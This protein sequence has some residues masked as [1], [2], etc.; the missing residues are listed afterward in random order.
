M[1]ETKEQ[2]RKRADLAQQAKI[3]VVKGILSGTY[4]LPS[5]IVELFSG[6]FVPGKAE[7]ALRTR[8]PGVPPD[9]PVEVPEGVAPRPELRPEQIGVPKVKYTSAD[10]ARRM[11]LDPDAPETLIAQLLAPDPFV[12]L[13]A[14][15]LAALAEGFGFL[16]ALGS[17]AQLGKRADK[18]KSA[19][20]S[21]EEIAAALNVTEAPTKSGWKK[22]PEKLPVQA[23][24]GERVMLKRTL[25][26]QIMA[27]DAMKDLRNYM[28]EEELLM[29]TPDTIEAIETIARTGKT[30]TGK[31]I[32]I[33]GGQQIPRL[34]KEDLSALAFAGR[35]KQG[36][37]RHG[38]EQLQNVF[39]EDT[40]RFIALLA[41]T[42]PRTS[43]EMNLENAL[44]VWRTWTDAGRPTDS[45]EIRR[46]MG[47]SVV[48]T[49]TE[50]SVMNVWVNNSVTAL[51]AKDPTVIELSGPK[52]DSFMRNLLSNLDE[53]TLDTWQGRAYNLLQEVF[54]GKIFKSTEGRGVKSPGYILSAA[55]T[56]RA[57][58]YLSKRT[59][60]TWK[61][62]EVQE[63]VWSFVKALY[64]KRRSP[65]GRAK[66]MDELYLE[67]S[68]NEIA[69]VPDF[70]SL[71]RTDKYGSILEGTEYGRRISS[72]EQ[73]Q[74]S[75]E[76]Y[77]A[78]PYRG[79]RTD[80]ERAVG[81]LEQQYRATDTTRIAKAIRDKI[82][83]GIVADRTGTGAV[84]RAFTSESARNPGLELRGLGKV[85]RHNLSK[86]D[87]GRL[88]SLGVSTPDYYELPQTI[89]AANVFEQSIKRSKEQNPF[90]ASVYVYTPAEYQHKRL[91]LTKDGKTGFAVAD[92]GDIVSVFNTKGSG[93]RASTVSM[94]LLA[95][96]N[97]GTKLDAF[98]TIL[99]QLYSSVGFR[100][101]SR[102]AWNDDFA[103]PGW[104]KELFSDYNQGEP[105][106]VFMHYDPESTEVF[107][108]LSGPYNPEDQVRT[109][110]L[111]DEYDDAVA[112]QAQNVVESQ[113]RFQKLKR[114][115]GEQAERLGFEIPKAPWKVEERSLVPAAAT[116]VAA[117]QIIEGLPL[118]RIQELT[119][120]QSLI[121][122]GS[123]L[124]PG[125]TFTSPALNA[126]REVSK[127]AL[128]AKQWLRQLQGRGV[129]EDEIEWTGVGDWLK[130]RKGNVSKADLEEYLDANQIQIQEVVYGN[131]YDIRADLFAA[132]PEPTKF[133]DPAYQLPGG[134][135]YR[136]LVL[137][138]PTPEKATFDPNKVTF[139]RDR[140]SVTQGTV[141]I[142]Y[143]GKELGNFGDR[144][145][146]MPDGSYQGYND[147]E[148]IELAERRLK[149]Y[150][151]DIHGENVISGAFR[152]G[153]YDEPNVVAHI[154][155]NERVDAD[156]NKVLFIEEIQSDWAQK[157]RD[158]GFKSPEQTK[159]MEEARRRREAIMESLHPLE[160]VRRWSDPKDLS[161]ELLAEYDQLTDEIHELKGGVPEAPFIMDTN[162]WVALSLKRMVRWAADNKFDKIGWTTGAQQAARY[163]LSKH[164]SALHY[165]PESG[166]LVAYGLDER[167]YRPELHG[168]RVPL[169][170]KMVPKSELSQHIGKEAARKLLETESVPLKYAKGTTRGEQGEKILGRYHM[171]EDQ[172]LEI[173]GEGMKGFY[174]QIVNDQAKALGK[175]YGAKVETSDI[176]SAHSLRPVTDGRQWRIYDPIFEDYWTN[177]ETRQI[178][179]FKSIEDAAA[180]IKEKAKGIPVS[181]LN[182]TPKLRDAARKGLPYMVVLPPVV[183]GS[184]MMQEESPSGNIEMLAG[185]EWIQSDPVPVPAAQ[186]RASRILE[187]AVP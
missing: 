70:A 108:Q 33:L 77:A 94:L 48:G 71:I 106:V 172:E 38:A 101:S 18:M 97:G 129:K 115:P 78:T 39:G 30:R 137:T 24:G 112:L 99:P 25:Q 104:N 43:V 153:H 128:P 113:Q 182:L 32:T 12:G 28:T 58:D 135:N 143:D 87:Q 144:I 157:G 61:P 187:E 45:K 20:K 79:F 86:Q 96:E 156:G 185:G 149:N 161:P 80:I 178:P 64:E 158:Q 68:P 180:T 1:A 141:K 107:E 14:K 66:S 76:A 146:L 118:S 121:G 60:T 91:F 8:P 73:F 114:F 126:V 53:V 4:G 165:D 90:G 151:E 117:D 37:Y 67:L 69:N 179:V 171:L 145:N 21:S 26:Q 84:K 110:L 59:G 103:P 155:F 92:D 162:Q 133:S 93:R 181:T 116:Q 55:A 109:S 136:E 139:L 89:E 11:G 183:I 85:V 142:F 5:D 111:R 166:H 42:S 52:A 123:M 72:V 10:L 150:P 81:G 16:G 65:G 40:E 132:P 167:R 23:F 13:K 9:K 120:E 54:G 148:I 34:E 154:R 175:K 29:L 74:P 169:V 138:L 19:G 46:I 160:T 88:N 163:D 131:P 168:Q 140:R 17:I 41:A 122:G 125:P 56:R 186:V 83:R 75:A 100:P 119:P 124:P 95:V 62:A 35:F 47:K 152:G 164:V 174:D 173:G 3:N 134:E 15:K 6:A 147:T 51:T 176:G 57:A 27:S 105:D 102:T 63:T 50:K 36:W 49:G 2:F 127:D 98:D 31:P 7:K 22:L 130:S 44:R 184:Q 177:P 159:R 82:H 170:D